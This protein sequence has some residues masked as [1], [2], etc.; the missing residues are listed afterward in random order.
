[1]TACSAH[2]RVRFCVLAGALLIIASPLVAQ[3]DSGFRLPIELFQGAAFTASGT[4][5]PFQAGVAIL[6]GWSFDPA[7][8]GL[9]LGLDYDDPSWRA[10]FGPRLSSRVVPVLRKDIGLILGGE[11]TTTTAGSWRYAANLTF[12]V[13]GLIRMGVAGGWQEV[14]DGTWFFGVTL[15]ADPTRW[16]S[17]VKDDFTGE[18]VGAAGAG[19]SPQAGNR[20]GRK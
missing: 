6:P 15:G 19:E 4:I 3:D 18:C 8:L 16:F 14:H 17:C 13:D 10:R 7:R 5:K 11:A 12:D 1:M 20:G 9:K 2:P